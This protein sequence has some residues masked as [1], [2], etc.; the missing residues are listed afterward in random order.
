MITCFER[1]LPFD[2]QTSRALGSVCVRQPESYERSTH[3]HIACASHTVLPSSDE[4]K[5]VLYTRNQ[6]SNTQNS[7][8]VNNSCVTR[9]LGNLTSNPGHPDHPSPVFSRQT[10]AYTNLVHN[11][12]PW[13]FWHSEKYLVCFVHVPSVPEKLN[14]KNS[15]LIICTRIDSAQS[16]NDSFTI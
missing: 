6:C 14:L 5:P 9:S 12:R 8:T 4:K 15:N 10:G 16:K 3:T 2:C 7:G 11:L 13:N 1:W